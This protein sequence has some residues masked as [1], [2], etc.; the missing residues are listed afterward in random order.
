M[1]PILLR[2][3]ML[4]AAILFV[5][6]VFTTVNKRRMQMGD[7]LIWLLISLGLIVLALV[8]QLSG[9]LANLMGIETP[10]N[11]LYLLGMFFLLAVAFFLTVRASTLAD[12]VKR[13][14]QTVSIENY[15]KEERERYDHSCKTDPEGLEKP[16]EDLLDG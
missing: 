7:S 11:L 15:L 13:L 16:S 2:V 8:P 4:V 9:W 6:M 5:V 3:E 14:I 10:A 12:R 1:I